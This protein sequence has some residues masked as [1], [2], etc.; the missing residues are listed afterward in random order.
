MSRLY[1]VSEISAATGVPPATLRL[2]EQHGLI[3]PSRTPSGYRLYSEDDFARVHQIVRL[4]SILGLNLAAIK[5]SL[6]EAAPV[7]SGPDGKT[8]D[9]T[10]SPRLGHEIRRLRK[11]KKL[12]IS[13][14]AGQLGVSASILSTLERTSRGASVPLLRAVAE[15]LGVTVTQLTASPADV[16]KAVV[17]QGEGRQLPSLGKGIRIRELA[18]GPRMMDCQEWTLAPGAGS[19]GFYQHEGEEFIRVLEGSFEIEVDG[20]GLAILNEGDS[21][22]FESHRAHC[23]RAAGM[24]PCRL[25]WV[26]TPPSF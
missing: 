10:P 7:S 11:E 17:R 25:L 4:R 2:W 24:R 26:N 1:K 3:T 6:E 18:S 23:W 13:A 5:S 21:I 8:G 19:E 9:D 22:Y 20:L 16:V 14:L 12:T 15:A